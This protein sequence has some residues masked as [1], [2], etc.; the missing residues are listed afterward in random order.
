MGEIWQEFIN[1]I[2]AV[3]VYLHGVVGS[4]GL[5]II[6]LTVMIRL[7]FLP[8]AIRSTRSMKE[9]AEAQAKIKPHM[10]V[11][12][13]KHGNDRQKLLEEQQKLYKEHGFNPMGSLG[14]CLPMLIQMPLWIALYSALLTLAQRPEFAA[15]FLWIPDLAQKGEGPP[16]ILTAFTG[17]SQWA[18]AKMAA[19]PAADDQSKTMNSMMQIMMPGMMVFFAFQVPIGLVLYWATTNVFQFLQQLYVTGWGELWPSRARKTAATTAA[20]SALNAVKNG[21]K[22]EGVEGITESVPVADETAKQERGRRNGKEAEDDSR[23]RAVS[24]LTEKTPSALKG[25]LR[26]YTLQPEKDGGGGDYTADDPS[27]SMDEAIARAKGQVRPKKR[28]RR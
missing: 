4:Y 6:V 23:P 7:V 26:I 3:L 24:L 27:T 13:K 1:L 25:G 20:A 18:T 19:Q 17:I 15:P 11:L 2:I 9:M 8:L 22:A 21:A 14:G 5:A 10:Q 28:R 16:F 12:Q